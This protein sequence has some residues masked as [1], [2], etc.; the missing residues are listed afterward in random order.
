MEKLAPLFDQLDMLDAVLAVFGALIVAMWFGA[1]K[2]P[3]GIV[4]GAV[5]GG[6]VKPLLF[7]VILGGA[8]MLAVP[9]PVM[10]DL[11]QTPEQQQKTLDFW[12]K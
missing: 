5:M 10:P 11:K 2:S 6:L 8:V 4:T 9:Q 12:T 7:G 3:M 1:G